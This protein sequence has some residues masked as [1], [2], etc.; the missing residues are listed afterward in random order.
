MRAHGAM[1]AL[2]SGGFTFFSGR[3]AAA[4]GFD[5]HRANGLLDDGRALTGAVAEPILDRTAKLD[6]LHELTA[7]RAIPLSATLAVGDG[8]NDLPMLRAAGLGVA[9][10]AKPVVAAEARARVDYADLRALLFVQG[11]RAAEIVGAG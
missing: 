6:L 4:V 2:V 11:Y 9:F 7:A 10:R 5:L 8:A 3:V 1:T